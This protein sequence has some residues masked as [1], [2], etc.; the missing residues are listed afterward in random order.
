MADFHVSVSKLDDGIGEVL[1]ALRA[2][3]MD[4]NTLV[5]SATD[6]GIAFPEMKTSLY[7]AGTG[8]HLIMR[9]PGGF[10]GGKICDTLLSHLDLFPTICDLL[11]I[12]D[13]DFLE[14][15]SFLPVIRDERDDVNEEIHAELNFHAA[16]EPK[17]SVR[18]KAMEVY[19]PL[20]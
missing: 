8:V 1:A 10:E 2:T 7:D 4:N 14:G 3:G 11:G 5:I 15:K 20:Q 6:H 13:P 12:P 17:R 19:S 18:T 16:Y 9:G